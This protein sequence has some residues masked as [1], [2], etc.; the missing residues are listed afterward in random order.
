MNTNDQPVSDLI[1]A[2]NVRTL[3]GLFYSNV[4]P[5]GT[6]PAVAEITALRSGTIPDDLHYFYEVRCSSDDRLPDGDCKPTAKIFP[7]FW[8]GLTAADVTKYTD[9]LKAYNVM[10]RQSEKSPMTVSA[11]IPAEL[12][13]AQYLAGSDWPA[14][15][16]M[17]IG[18]DQD[19]EC[20]GDAL[21]DGWRF[22][23]WTRAATFDAV[24]IE[25]LSAKPVAIGEIFGGRSQDTKL[26]LAATAPGTEAI[27][28]LAA[29]LAR[30]DKILVPTRIG[31]AA[32]DGVGQSVGNE[33][34]SR[35]EF[36][37]H[38][39]GRFKGAAKGYGLPTCRI[40]RTECSSRSEV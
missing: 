9:N 6:Y 23:Y 15:F 2:T 40:T 27:G 19:E 21:S 10:L 35:R 30:G 17:M 11:G 32:K 7:K 3:T 18:D 36:E 33:D 14:D 39:T 4:L 16:I 34:D 29:T 13:L 38:G 26:R 22:N 24:I 20:A 31:F 28:N 5:D 25:N 1:G 12:K 37:K 8:R